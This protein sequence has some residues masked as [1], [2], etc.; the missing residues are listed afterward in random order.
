MVSRENLEPSQGD[1]GKTFEVNRIP[2]NDA[3]GNLAAVLAISRNVDG[4]GEGDRETS[5]YCLSEYWSNKDR[6][7][8]AM[9]GANDGLW[10]WNMETE[11]GRA[12]V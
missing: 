3:S 8:L 7:A 5:E 2:I 12:H 11:I 4:E 6:F 10:D 9:R 1:R